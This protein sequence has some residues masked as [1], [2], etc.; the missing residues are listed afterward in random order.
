MV[1]GRYLYSPVLPRHLD[2]KLN[3]PEKNRSTYF[4]FEGL[5]VL[6]ETA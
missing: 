6:V 1:V 5:L 4:F 3:A 2:T